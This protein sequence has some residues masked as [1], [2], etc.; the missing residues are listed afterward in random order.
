MK[1]VYIAHSSVFDFEK[2][3][4]EP[5]KKSVEFEFIFPHAKENELKDSNELIKGCD[6]VL[7]EI[8]YPSTG[9]G[10]EIGRAEAAGIPIVAI[11]KKGSGISSSMKFVT[12]N[13][14]AYENLESDFEKIKT[15]IN[16]N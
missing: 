2:E 10:I 1:K 15:I 9:M 5:L 12:N 8:T 6:F 11:Y 16:N 3:L 7:A 14:I 4:Y 13:I